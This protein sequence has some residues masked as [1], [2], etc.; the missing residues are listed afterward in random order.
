MDDF[1]RPLL[2]LNKAEKFFSPTGRMRR[3]RGWLSLPKQAGEAQL[4][5]GRALACIFIAIAVCCSS[6]AASEDVRVEEKH[7]ERHRFDV[8]PQAVADSLRAI[9]RQ[10]GVG[11]LFPQELVA[12]AKANALR[13]TY[14]LDEAL[15][16]LLDGTGLQGRVNE[17]GVLVIS[18]RPDTGRGKKVQNTNTETSSKGSLFARVS[19][20]ALAVFATSGA[21]ADETV[22]PVGVTDEII[23]SA[24]RRDE[25]IQTAPVSVSAFTGEQ[26]TKSGYV[27]A[28]QFLDS[29][30][31]VTS[32]AEGAGNNVVII[33]N[34]ATS[35]Q[36]QGGAVTATYFDDFPISGV[37]GG[38]PEMRL[39]DMQRVEVLKGPQGTLFGRSA[40][41]GIVRYIANKPTTEGVAG[42]INTYLSRTTDGG[43]NVGG[44]AYLNMPL[45]E[46]IAARAVFYTYQNDGFLNNVELGDRNWN[47]ES[48][49]GGRFAIR[50][51]PTDTLTVD[52]TYVDQNT[53][54]APNWV[55]DIHT[56]AGDIPFDPKA[57]TMVGGIRMKEAWR[58]Q[59][60]N[61]RIE[62]EFDPFMVTLLGTH[63]RQTTEFVFDQREYVDVT[64]GCV[65]DFLDGDEHS[66]VSN[67]DTLELRV[68]SPKDQLIDYIFGFYYEDFEDSYHQVIRYFGPT[69]DIFGGF[70][71]LTDGLLAVDTIL[72][73]DS[74]E[75]AGYGEVGFNVTDGTRLAFGYR[76]SDVD[77]GSIQT[78]ADGIFSLL[79]G[80]GLVTGI[81]FSTNEKVSTY[82]ATIEHQF[83]DNLFGYVLASSG[84]RR[85]GFNLP[86]IVSAFS[87]YASDSLWNYEVGLKSSWLDG[88]L[89]ANV[90]A[91]YLDFK[92]IQL[93]VQDPLTFIRATQNA[94][95]ARIPGVEA[96]LALQPTDY[97]GF[98]FA[99]SWSDPEL[100]EDVP[101]GASGKKG[102]RLPGSA[103]KSF[104]FSANLDRP[105]GN[106]YSLTGVATYKYVGKRFNDFN[107][108]LD[109]VLPSYDMLDL[110]AGV[111]SDKGYSL[112]I[113]ADNVFDEAAIYRV[114]HQGSFFNVAP[115]SRP[116]TI[117][118]NLTY[119]F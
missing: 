22:K 14:T 10:G 85:G 98:T 34:V 58:N 40:M 62:K 74:S 72:K 9:A 81:P 104:S 60:A 59:F 15:A 83:N 12:T 109:V 11:I 55:S 49:L 111:R 61:V 2:C 92:D 1:R 84:Y 69:Q 21:F 57:R 91:F 51:T 56:G 54:A 93:V 114:D 47:D 105:I 13:G 86:T 7:V 8:P 78:Q 77:Y 3:A 110:R 73:T 52:L 5:F 28:G 32:L 53:D 66:G 20:F 43:V 64:T 41:G 36:E 89:I 37:Y 46:N 96:S 101:G 112:S 97:V 94:G 76:W 90:S 31:G 33:R 18:A 38:V 63:A 116:R 113:F 87:A 39:V 119:D 79:T 88:R 65:C 100:R 24:T 26:L 95:K 107:E 71:T 29:V 118:V 23:V 6:A 115:T 48:T 67:T 45:S 16:V 42:G 25:S 19:S 82:K 106:G 35:T 70:L 68:V 80:A 108:T 117:G 30:P 4:R 27:G 103:T 50:W 75:M 102:D 44:H 17:D 99:G